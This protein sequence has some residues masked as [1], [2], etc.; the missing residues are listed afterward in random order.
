MG[1]LLG[2]SIDRLNAVL[3]SRGA[4]PRRVDDTPA[5]FRFVDE[6]RD[7]L[8]PLS[9]PEEIVDLWSWEP[10]SFEVLAAAQIEILSPEVC[11]EEYEAIVGM[12]FPRLLFPVAREGQRLLA[13]ELGCDSHPGMRLFE[14]GFHGE[15]LCALGVGVADLIDHFSDAVMHSQ[16]RG[17]PEGWT[18]GLLDMDIYHEL[19]NP[20]SYTHLTLPT[21]CSV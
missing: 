4:K 17:Q 10:D 11:V 2:E 5:L 8:A 14:V 19:L 20:V 21:I 12:W 9:L 7:W 3:A 13:I 16:E 1:I 18:S 6:L 15:G